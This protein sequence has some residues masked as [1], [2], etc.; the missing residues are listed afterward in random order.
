MVF[1]IQHVKLIKKLLKTR[2]INKKQKRNESL[3]SVEM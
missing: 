3:E 2:L 1:T